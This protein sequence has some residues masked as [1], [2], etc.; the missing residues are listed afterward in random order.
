MTTTLEPPRP[1]D[2]SPLESARRRAAAG[3]GP[4]PSQ[5]GNFELYSWFFMR[6]SGIFLAF[7]ALGHFAITHVINDVADT[8]FAFV[9]DRYGTIFW[10]LWDLA[11]GYLAL[12]HGTNGARIVIE[13]Y[14]RRPGK[15]AYLKALLYSVVIA[16]LLLT[17]V[18]ILTF[19]PSLGDASA[20]ILDSTMGR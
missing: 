16:M 7:L 19:D 12:L 2:V 11:L 1:K 8:S 18:S 5:F 3:M 10:R 17:T 9:A 20:A 13:D 6:V 15:R 4:K 14:V